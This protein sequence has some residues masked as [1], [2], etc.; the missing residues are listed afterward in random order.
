MWNDISKPYRDDIQ[1]WN[2]IERDILIDDLEKIGWYAGFNRVSGVSGVIDNGPKFPNG[3]PNIQKSPRKMM[4]YD[5]DEI[6]NPGLEVL[7]KIDDVMDC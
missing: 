6:K 4:I 3:T 2:P 5:G 7:E 1:T